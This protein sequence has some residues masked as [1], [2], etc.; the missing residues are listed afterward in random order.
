MKK[1]FLILFLSALFIPSSAIASS[2]DDEYSV[3]YEEGYEDAKEKYDG[4][5]FV[6]IVGGF[7]LGYGFHEMFISKK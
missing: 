6:S 5:D 7:I 3:G 2:Y 1:L 4:I